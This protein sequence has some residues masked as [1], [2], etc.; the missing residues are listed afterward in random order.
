MRKRK[1]I[2]CLVVVMML[3]IL[4]S[5]AYAAKKVKLSSKKLSLKVGQKKT[6]KLKNNKKKVKWSVVSGKKFV[7]LSAKKKTG[8]TI[9]GKKKG[10]AKVQAKIGKKKYTCKVVVKQPR[11]SVKKSSGKKTVKPSAKPTKLPT[12]K[13]VNTPSAQP[14]KKVESI[15]YG[16]GR[17]RKYVFLESGRRLVDKENINLE[18]GEVD[19]GDLKTE[20]NVKYTDGSEEKAS[21]EDISLDFSQINYEKIGAYDIIITYEGCTCKVPVV[22]AERKTEGLYTY[23]TD[24]NVA[25][26]VEMIGDKKIENEEGEYI[27]ELSST[28][29][30]I[31]ETLG[32]AK[33]VQGLPEFQFSTTK[34][35]RVKFPKFY[36][37]DYVA[38]TRSFAGRYY[39]EEFM[40][41]E[42]FVVDGENDYYTVRDNVLFAEN[43]TVLCVYP[44]GLMATSYQIPEGVTRGGGL[45]DWEAFADNLHLT[46]ITFP[47]SYIG[48][49]EDN[50]VYENSMF[51]VPNLKKINVADGN[52]CWCSID[53]VLYKKEKDNKL[54]LWSYP[55]Q[56]TDKS[57]TVEENVVGTASGG[58]SSNRYLENITFKSGTISIGY[59]AINGD[60]IKNIYLDFLSVPY[61]ESEMICI[62]SSFSHDVELDDSAFLN[63]NIYIRD[64]S[65][66]NCIDESLRSK[67]VYY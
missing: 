16:G 19:I 62:E 8:V 37:P 17:G 5:E 56:K 38:V 28:T 12:K 44:A 43:N 11:K 25:E 14:K 20:V 53:G 26:L 49:R 31:P 13:P 23:L 50:E 66:L 34:I 24:G 29:L 33:V 61:G 21:Y 22:I 36:Q 55:P 1:M 4:P 30:E 2:M 10:T 57:F 9:K 59:E 18:D 47:K 51:G 52:P 3:S 45:A 35:K 54:T 64:K 67:V 63:F 41:L 32:G 6:L 15:S 39:S 7:K 48:C 58:L 42:E 60:Y 40:Q 46:E 27:Y 65:A